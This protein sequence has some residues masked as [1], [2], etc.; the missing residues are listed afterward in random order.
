MVIKFSFSGQKAIVRSFVGREDT[1]PGSKVEFLCGETNSGYLLIPH[2]APPHKC[3]DMHVSIAIIQNNVL[4][5]CTPFLVMKDL[6]GPIDTMTEEEHSQLVDESIIRL[7]HQPHM[8]VNRPFFYRDAS[9]PLPIVIYANLNFL[10]PYPHTPLIQ[11]HAA[12]AKVYPDLPVVEANS[13]PE[14]I[15]TALR[16]LRDEMMLSRRAL[17][18]AALPPTVSNNITTPMMKSLRAG[19]GIHMKTYL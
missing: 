16:I 18:K 4:S 12:P 17:E 9:R 14:I 2:V 1:V 11:E 8:K 3:G 15:A 10:L 5:L 13:I 7:V 6:I 19:D